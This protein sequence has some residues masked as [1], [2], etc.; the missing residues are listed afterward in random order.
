MRAERRPVELAAARGGLPGALALPMLDPGA[1]SG[2]VLV[3]V[4]PDGADYRPDEVELLGWGANQVG[5]DLQ[6]LHAR[7]LEAQV[8]SLNEKVAWLTEDR[9][10]L[11][12]L[13]AGAAGLQSASS[14][15]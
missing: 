10:R 7:D 4:K 5:L 9:A 13:L 1:L 2:F 14:A 11:T 12:A 8:I 6:A 3:G 15:G